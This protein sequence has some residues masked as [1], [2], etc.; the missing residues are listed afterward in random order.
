MGFLDNL[1]NAAKTMAQEGSRG[2]AQTGQQKSLLEGVV[3]MFKSDGVDGIMRKFKEGGLEETLKSWIGTGANRNI[4]A[5]QLRN[6]LG[7]DRIRELSQ[8]TGIPPERVT[9]EL[10]EILPDAVDRAT[11]DGTVEPL[12]PDQK[13]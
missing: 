10:K 4:S 3:D 11:P 13:Q 8:K 2:A 9:E 1:V 12:D 7:Q 5:D 6:V